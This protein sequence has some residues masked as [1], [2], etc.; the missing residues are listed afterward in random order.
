[1]TMSADEVVIMRTALGIP[2]RVFSGIKIELVNT[3]P[4]FLARA[5]REFGT[6][7]AAVRCLYTIRSLA[8]ASCTLVP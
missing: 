8:D 7:P 1:M 4:A 2:L 5:E 3:P 6:T